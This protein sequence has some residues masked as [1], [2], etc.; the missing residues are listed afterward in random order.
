[1]SRYTGPKARLCRREGVDLFGRPKYAK[2]LEK[3]PG[4]PGMHSGTPKKLSGYA[5]QLREKQKL[6][7]MFG[8]TEGKLRRYVDQALRNKKGLTSD[9][10]MQQLELRLDNAIYRAGL[11]LTRFQARQM[12]THGHFLINGRRV[13]VPSFE[14]SEGDKVE[15]RPKLKNSKLYPNVLEEN[16]GYR[17]ARWMNV[18]AKNFSMEITGMPSGDDFEKII[19]TQKIIEFYSR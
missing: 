17:P 7:I 16:K 8:L 18:N 5:S 14:L 1:M 9:N 19:D 10:L 12:A 2:I 13:D 6:R 4:G 11:A 15:L 3:R